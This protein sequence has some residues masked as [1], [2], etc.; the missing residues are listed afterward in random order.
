[1]SH[2][3]DSTDL[4]LPVRAVVDLKGRVSELTDLISERLADVHQE[5]G[6]AALPAEVVG[7]IVAA[8]VAEV[9]ARP[10]VPAAATRSP[11]TSGRWTAGR[12]VPPHS[13]LPEAWLLTWADTTS[14]ETPVSVRLTSRCRWNAD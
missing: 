7:G 4:V 13:I 14:G 1:V 3:W 6:G 12:T 9:R 10:D 8:A 11:G 2:A 5:A